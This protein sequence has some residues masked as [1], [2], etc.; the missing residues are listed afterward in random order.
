MHA[1]RARKG[2]PANVQANLADSYGESV[3]DC[4]Y[5][6]ATSIRMCAGATLAS[7]ESRI[8]SPVDGIRTSL[9]GAPAFHSFNKFTFCG[10]LR[11][12]GIKLLLMLF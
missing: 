12:L 10:E 1:P 2:E 7:R 8:S 3:S 5:L 6:F 11:F 4:A 9:F